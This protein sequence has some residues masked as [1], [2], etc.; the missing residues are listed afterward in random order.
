MPPPH[1]QL[2]GHAVS[3]YF[4]TVHAVLIEKQANFEIVTCGASRD[5]AFLARSPLGKIPFLHTPHGDISET[6]PI[7]EYLEET[8]DGPRLHP[9]DPL[10]RARSRQIMNVTQLYLDTPLRRLY[11]GV[12]AAGRNSS[13]TKHAVATQ[14]EITLLG[15]ERL[16]VCDPYLLGNAPTLTDFFCFYTFDLSDRVTQKVYGWSLLQRL[17]RLESWATAMRARASTARVTQQFLPALSAYLIDKQAHY[18]LSEG[19]G[20]ITAAHTLSDMRSPA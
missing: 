15:L 5:D 4:N 17:P 11:P 3:N 13:E 12:Y 18:Q 8:L 1:L 2:H 14:L 7:L 16:L 10:L 9:E 19:S 6:L 20:L